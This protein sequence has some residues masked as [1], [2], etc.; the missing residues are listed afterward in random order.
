[1]RDLKAT[2]VTR[3]GREPLA[4]EVQVATKE[5]LA[6]LETVAYQELLEHLATVVQLVTVACVELQG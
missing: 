5:S 1:M 6:W 4:R 2:M 3:V